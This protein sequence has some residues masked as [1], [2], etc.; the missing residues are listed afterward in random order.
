[1]FCTAHLLNGNSENNFRG[2]RQLMKRKILIVEDVKLNRE[3]IKRILCN[4]YDILEAQNGQEALNIMDDKAAGLSAVLLDLSMPVM[5]GFEVLSHMRADPKLKQLPVIVTTGQTEDSS[6]VKALQMG[7][8]DY[9]SKP[10]N[11]AII[12]QRIWNAINLQET[13]AVVNE[14][15]RDHLTGL[16]SRNTF[17]EI[18]TTMIKDKGP[19]TM[20]W[21]VLT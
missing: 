17:I 18:A 3:I 8:N 11:A 1:M 7:A 4:E 16:Y 9:V 10:Y 5:N 21:Y 14:L 13:A 19:D 6:E 15:R 20:S 12:R 2:D